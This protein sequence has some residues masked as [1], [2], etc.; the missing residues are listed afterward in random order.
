MSG[1][2][3]FDVTSTV[4]HSR[5]GL[6]AALSVVAVIGLV[7]IAVA[8]LPYFLSF[9]PDQ[10]KFY[11]PRRWWLMVHISAGIVALLSGPVQLWFGLT[12]RRMQTH[13][14][15]GIVYMTSVG[16]SS[17]AA[18]YLSTH[19]DLG[20]V[21]GAGLFSL[22]TAWLTTTGLA[23]V[24][25]RRQLYDQ[26]K[27]WMIRS[28]VVTTAFVSFRLLAAILDA[29]HVGDLRDQLAVAAWFC[30]A[31]PLLITEAVLQGRKILAVKA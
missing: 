20:W 17:V 9:T 26:H 28:Y 4:K 27:E 1:S 18:Y 2:I 23:F 21:F 3:A 10:F 11:W 7:F 8:A 14:K 31:V 22:A 30:W 5:R 19:T 24:A 15:L 13:R 25:I 12:D 6:L 16:L 29:T